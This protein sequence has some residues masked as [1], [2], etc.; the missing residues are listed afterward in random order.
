MEYKH[1][2]ESMVENQIKIRGITDERVLKAM[3]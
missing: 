3:L 1:Q 2:R